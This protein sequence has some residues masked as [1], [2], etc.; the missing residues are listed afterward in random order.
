MAL[1]D[2]EI[3]NCLYRGGL[4]N[5]MK[6]LCRNEDFLSATNEKVLEKRLKNRML[7][8]RFLAFYQMSYLNA[9]K[10]L[11]GFF[12]EFF[13]TYPNP[14]PSK[15]EEF[16]DKF[17]RSMKACVRC[18]C[19]LSLHAGK[20]TGMPGAAGRGEPQTSCANWSVS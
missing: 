19:C 6:E 3:R 5:S 17:R 2:M 12:N 7:V 16:R 20:L 8:L 9:R 4:N 13:T 14:T 18:A 11:K 10:G 15:S 1:N